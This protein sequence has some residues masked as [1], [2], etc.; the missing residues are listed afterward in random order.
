MQLS[1]ADDD[2]H[3]KVLEPLPGDWSSEN[4]LRD[5]EGLVADLM[6]ASSLLEVPVGVPELDQVS[7]SGFE[8]QAGS[9]VSLECR[10]DHVTVRRLPNGSPDWKW[11]NRVM[12]LGRREI[13]Q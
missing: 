11:I 3:Q 6:A 4:I 9:S 8:L 2:L 13:G 12:I 5:V 10:V 1:F 7:M